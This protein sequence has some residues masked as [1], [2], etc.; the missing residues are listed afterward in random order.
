[1]TGS[2]T[3]M[4]YTLS[5]YQYGVPASLTFQPD[6]VPHRQL[7]REQQLDYK[8]QSSFR[9][10]PE[11]VSSYLLRMEYRVRY[12]RFFFLAPLYLA[13]PAFF[14]AL[15]EYL[16]QDSGAS[17]PAHLNQEFGASPC[18]R[19]AKSIHRLHLLRGVDHNRWS[20]WAAIAKD[21]RLG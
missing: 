8:M 21:N 9:S 5:Q 3:T 13:L 12:Y 1:V 20:S 17:L 10:G 16:F 18:Q 6:P 7:T 19:E 11:T 4:P 2:F 15:R 14:F